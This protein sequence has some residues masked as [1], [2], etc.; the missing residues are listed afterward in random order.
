[1][2]LLSRFFRGDTRLEACLVHDRSH[3]TQ[4]ANGDHVRKIQTALFI[5]DALKI[6]DSELSS[7]RYGPATAAAVLAYKTRRGIINHRYQT[8][9]DNIVGKMTIAALDR[10][11]FKYELAAA[12]PNYCA[13]SVPVFLPR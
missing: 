9:P 1:M 13:T 4:G 6:D 7:N 5:L 12:G 2:S 11:I 8:K 3:I 10:E